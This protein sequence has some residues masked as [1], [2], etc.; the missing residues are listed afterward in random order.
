MLGQAHT[1]RRRLLPFAALASAILV[2][3]AFGGANASH[4]VASLRTHDAQI[5]ARSRSAALSLYALD[6]RLAVANTQLQSLHKRAQSL[7]SA[8]RV[9]QLQIRIA[10]RS[11]VIAQHS[12]AQRLRTLYEEGDVEPI[13][14]LLG[15]QNLED[16][17]TNLDNL[18]RASQDGQDDLAALKTAKAQLATAAGN[19]ARQE[20]QLAA[21]TRSAEASAAALSQTRAERSAYIGSLAAQHRLTRDAIATAVASARAAEARSVVVT[22]AAPA[23]VSEAATP[24]VQTETT[25]GRSLGVVATGYA[26]G[27]QTSTGLPVGWGVAAVDP[28]VIP[29]GT[30]MTVPGY[31]EAVAADIGGSVRGTVIDLWFPTVAQA[32]AWG[33][34]SVTVVL[35]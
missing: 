26:L 30:H 8:R 32:N 20:A 21:A 3:P 19:L 6:H 28:S 7:E 12:L 17:M 22:A 13:E 33:R 35:H 29:L 2:A 34:R 18:S 27:G 10:R 25:T 9:L 23:P 15:S 24:V 5:E 11:T 14:I 4:R 1:P 31:G 16:A